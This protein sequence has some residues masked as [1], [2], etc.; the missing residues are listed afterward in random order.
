MTFETLMLIHRLLEQEEIRTNEA[1]KKARALQH[2]YEETGKDK[3]AIKWQEETADNFMKIHN[4][5]YNAL[6]EFEQHEWR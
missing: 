5:A 4:K 1:Y 6:A 3:S 2:E